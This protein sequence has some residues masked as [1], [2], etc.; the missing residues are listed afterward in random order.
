MSKKILSDADEIIKRKLLVEFIRKPL[1]KFKLFGFILTSN[2]EFTLISEFDRDLFITDSY[3]VFRNDSVQKYAVYNNVNYFL[4]EVIALKKIKPKPAPNVSIENWTEVVRSVAENFPLIVI[5]REN[6]DNKACN[7]GK[8]KKISKKSFTL[9]E[10]D[11]NA[12]W[13]DS[14]SYNFADLTKVRFGGEY[15][16]TLALVAENRDKLNKKKS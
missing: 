7:I 6:V 11:G 5:E 2:D 3:C 8:L 12:E 4:N 16:N 13:E 14:Y 10:I 9:S 15:E 1:D